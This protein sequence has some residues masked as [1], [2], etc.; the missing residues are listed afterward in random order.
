MDLVLPG[1]F[2]G[3]DKRWKV[4]CSEKHLTFCWL[5]SLAT[6]QFQ[7][8]LVC[9]NYQSSLPFLALN[10]LLAFHVLSFH[11]N[12]LSFCFLSSHF[13]YSV[14]CI[15]FWFPYC[16][17]TAVLVG[18]EDKHGIKNIMFKWRSYCNM[19]YNNIYQKEDL[20]PCPSS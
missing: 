10:I 14:G 8:S 5:F 13:L 19:T 11:L 2:S 4:P 17:F 7:L 12:F 15:S 6:I 18:C 3:K 9:Y 20:Q 1:L 16:S